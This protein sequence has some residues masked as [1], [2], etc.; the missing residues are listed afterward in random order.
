MIR[1]GS[2]KATNN[3]SK[4][5]SLKINLRLNVLNKTENPNLLECFAGDSVLWNEVE[6]IK[7]T[8]IKKTTIDADQRYNVDFNM[9]S[10]TFL[11][12]NN[13]NDYNIIDLDSWGS[14]V[15][16][17]EILFLKK[18]K[19]FVICTYCSPVRLNPDKILAEN[20]YGKIYN[21][22]NSKSI[23]NKDVGKLFKEYLFSKGI[24]E[25]EGLIT[26]NKIY[27]SFQIK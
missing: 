18:Y 2:N 6:K 14:P 25:Y 24:K 12:N 15:K 3:D 1:T 17:L 9:N 11:K 16:H 23:L 13:I 19:G 5:L 27:C 10:L 21:S 20:F 4:Y 26:H 7:L 22:T 8:K